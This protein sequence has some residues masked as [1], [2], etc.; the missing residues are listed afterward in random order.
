MYPLYCITSLTQ[1]P[2]MLIEYQSECLSTAM[3]KFIL[4]CVNKEFFCT[5]M[6]KILAT[7]DV[8]AAGEF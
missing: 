4:Q 8:H 3:C 1:I 7:L 2:E 6:C 5:I